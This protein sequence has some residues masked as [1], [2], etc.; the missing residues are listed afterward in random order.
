MPLDGPVP[1]WLFSACAALTLWSIM[2]HVGMAIEPGEFRWI[3]AHFGML[4]KGLFSVLVAVPALA[5]TVVRNLE[6]V[7]AVEIGIVLMSISPGAPVALRR[8]IEAGGRRAYATSLQIALAIFAV[9]SMPLWIAVLD[10]LYDGTAAIDPRE[11]FRQVFMAQL[12]P[13]GIGILL[14]HSAPRLSAWL[15]PRLGPLAS[16]LLLLMT[17]LALMTAWRSVIDAGPHVALAI[18]VTSLLALACGHLLGGPEPSTRTATAI[19][20]AARNP[21]LALLV[22]ALNGASP[23]IVATVLAY[24]VISAFTILPYVFWR[25]ALARRQMPR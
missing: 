5:L 20:S 11:L 13:L 16:A 4:L 18:V 23:T 3:R 7:R 2:I 12:L 14:R 9:L 22:V 25:R 8:A 1:A 17:L 24:L 6:L 21:G 19:A 15:L 10:R